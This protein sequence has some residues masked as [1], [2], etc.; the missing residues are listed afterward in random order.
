[1][2]VEVEVE[3][4]RWVARGF[5]DDVTDCQHCGRTDLKG[6]VRMEALSADNESMGDCYMGVVCAARMAGRKAA[7]IRTEANRAD[8]ERRAALVAAWNA[9][10]DA[11]VYE[12]CARRDAALGR[13]V[14]PMQC[15]EWSRTPAA[16]A[17]D[18][19]WLADNPPPPC[20]W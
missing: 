17:G 10:R 11:Q 13:D 8:R 15:I 7:E 4:F 6:T 12:Y 5:T 16:K 20:P 19:A 2:L 18:A 9:W 1:M 3:R 14:N